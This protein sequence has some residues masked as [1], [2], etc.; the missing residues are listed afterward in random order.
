MTK[1]IIIST[2]VALAT[3][4]CGRDGY[5]SPYLG[6]DGSNPQKIQDGLPIG[7]GDDPSIQYYNDRYLVTPGIQ[8]ESFFDDQFSRAL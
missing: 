3:S 4:A 7:S 8:I 2:I 1:L 5:R 6:E